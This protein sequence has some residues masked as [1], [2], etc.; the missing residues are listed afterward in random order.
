MTLASFRDASDFL[1]KSQE[2]PRRLIRLMSPF[3]YFPVKALSFFLPPPLLKIRKPAA[4]SWPIIPSFSEPEP[5][6]RGSFPRFQSL[7]LMKRAQWAEIPGRSQGFRVHRGQQTQEQP[8]LSGCSLSSSSLLSS[9]P[10]LLSE[11]FGWT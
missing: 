8:I 2:V 10:F 6:I 4:L 11:R 5:R 7:L 3:A 1:G 9:F